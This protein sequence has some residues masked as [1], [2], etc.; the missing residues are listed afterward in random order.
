MKTISLSLNWITCWKIKKN[1]WSEFRKC[2]RYSCLEIFSEPFRQMKYFINIIT[3]NKIVVK[4]RRPACFGNLHDRKTQYCFFFESC[5]HVHYQFSSRTARRRPL[6]AKRENTWITNEEDS[7]FQKHFSLFL[8]SITC[9]F[10][11][12]S[13]LQEQWILLF[14]VLLNSGYIIWLWIDNVLLFICKPF[15][16]EINRH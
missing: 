15:V 7:H 9:F 11:D 6:L 5:R 1:K 4:W 13:S 3:Y 16:F 12:L 10:V 8:I 2:K 14:T